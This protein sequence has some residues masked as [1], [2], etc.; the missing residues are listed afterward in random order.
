[1]MRLLAN[2]MRRLADR[3]DHAGAPKATH[4]TMTIESGKGIV[5][6]GLNGEPEPVKPRGC[7]LWYLNDEEYEKVHTEAENPGIWVDWKTGTT[8]S[9]EEL[10]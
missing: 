7:T 4:L 10:P 1:M 5:I 3:I 2:A 6:H 9:L 8:R